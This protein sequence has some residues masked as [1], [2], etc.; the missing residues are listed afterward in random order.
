VDTFFET[1]ESRGKTM[2]RT[3]YLGIFLALALICSYIETLIPFSI[4]IPGVKLGLANIVVV[5]ALYLMGAKEALLI[6]ILRILLSGMMFG[7]AFSIAY[8]MAGGLLSFA[9][10]FLL[11]HTK[12]FKCITVSVTGGIFHN[13]G[14]LLVAALIVQSYSIFYYIPILLFAG[15]VTGLLIGIVS[16]ELII[17]VKFRGW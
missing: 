15:L 12:K 4:G 16:Q 11:K 1:L 3:A 7:N 17:R 2:K 6:S 10:M 13:I 8:S 5:W 14:Q 9:A